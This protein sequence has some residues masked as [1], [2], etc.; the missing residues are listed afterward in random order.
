VYVL[1]DG[2]QLVPPGV[3]GEL[4]VAGAGLARGYLN[5]PGLTGERFVPCPFSEPGARMY[6][7]GDLVRWRQDGNLEFVGRADHQVKIRGFRI[8]L[9]EIEA[10][11]AKQPGIA[12]AAVIVREYQPGDRRI[13]AYVVPEPQALAPDADQLRVTLAEQL[14]AHMLPAAFV[15]MDQLP[16]TRNGKLDRDALPAP[17]H[18]VQA[19]RRAPRTAQ[20]EILCALFSEI[21]GVEGIG[22]DHSFF[23]LGGHSLLATRLVSAIRTTLG[24][25]LPVRALFETPTPAGLACRILGRATP[26][27]DPLA[28]VLPLRTEGSRTPLL[29]VHPAIGLSWVYSGLLANLDPQQPVY[30]LQAR[31]YSQAGHRPASVAEMAADYL[32][33]IRKVLPH[34][35]YALLGWSFGGVVAHALARL[36]QEEGE[37]VTV[38]ALLD[39]HPYE[40][41]RSPARGYDHPTVMAEVVASIGHDPRSPESPLA[42]LG[43]E[44]INTLTKVFTDITN[45]SSPV[46]GKFAGDMLFFEAAGRMGEDI[47]S[48]GFPW[49][50]HV[51]GTVE[52]VRINCRHGEMTE[53]ASLREIGRVLR[54]WLVRD[55]NSAV[56]RKKGRTD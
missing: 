20:E 6:R 5:R 4:Y 48:N 23:D 19:S 1:D 27:Q 45:M 54:T 32:H 37:A 26:A 39:S 9:G 50:E 41:T 18:S 22:I 36:L 35:P 16:L 25:E 43:P 28:V 31:A 17:A 52:T 30:G 10:A 21:L 2:L 56:W 34:G 44:T 29:C 3:V 8:E 11:L 49:Q 24:A 55:S 47:A 40:M 33:E 53:P 38:L 14:P 7:T 51:T 15:M 46:S 12:Q 42:G 13:V